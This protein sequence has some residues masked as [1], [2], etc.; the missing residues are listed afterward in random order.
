MEDQFPKIENYMHKGIP[1]GSA[2][3]RRL[4]GDPIL[5]N[6]L[7]ETS[8][9]ANGGMD[10]FFSSPESSSSVD[11]ATVVSLNN[12][13]T[14]Y[15]ERKF[16]LA[17]NRFASTNATV[18]ESQSPFNSV[19]SS[20]TTS[21]GSEAPEFELVLEEPE[22]NVIGPVAHQVQPQPGLDWFSINNKLVGSPAKGSR[23][24][25][26]GVNK[27]QVMK[28]SGS[29]NQENQQKTWASTSSQGKL[30]RGV[31]Q[32]H[33]GKWVAEI[34]LPRNRSRVWLGTFDT[35]EEAAFA[36]DTAAYKL[37]G[38]HAQLNFPDLKHQLEANSLNGSSSTAAL[39]D[40]KLQALCVGIAQQKKPPSP[41]NLISKS[42]LKPIIQKANNER[43]FL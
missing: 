30:F 34:R 33:W 23:D 27:T 9:C 21:E 25:C 26:L 43:Q 18:Q 4:L 37:R 8:S 41:N 6:A 32:R 20:V 14:G 7:A 3:S 16:E 31:R 39:L 2:T 35:A 22:P 5:W 12:N 40:A 10:Q 1:Y 11:D 36:Y 13:V 29:K 42:P 28:Y 24:Y 19:S 38:E 15:G 17:N